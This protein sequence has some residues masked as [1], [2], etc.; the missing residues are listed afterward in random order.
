V[1]SDTGLVPA[2]IK[3]PM[4]KLLVGEMVHARITVGQ[5]TGFIVPHAAIMIDLDDGST[6]VMQSQKLVA[7]QVAVQVLA[8]DGNQDLISGDD[9]DAKAPVV[10]EG[11]MQLTDGMKM[12]LAEA[13]ASGSKGAG[14]K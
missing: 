12:R 6:Y 10:V 2:E 14:S 4:G 9:L 5:K 7:K 3:F 13:A 8:T 1:N 11:G